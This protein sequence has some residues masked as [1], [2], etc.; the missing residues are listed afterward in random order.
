MQA[1]ATIS[2]VVIA[3]LCN[4]IYFYMKNTFKKIIYIS[5]LNFSAASVY[6]MDKL[7]VAKVNKD[8]Y[9]NFFTIVND[10]ITLWLAIGS[11]L[12]AAIGSGSIKDRAMAAGHGFAVALVVYGIF[13]ALMN[14]A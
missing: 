4:L 5:L 6:A 14:F 10:N 3:A 2:E 7:E 1:T 12:G 9:K 8:L 13:K 11:F